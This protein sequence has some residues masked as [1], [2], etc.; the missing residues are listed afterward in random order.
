MNEPT[1]T[2]QNGFRK[3]LLTTVSA[4]ALLASVHGANAADDESSHPPLWIELGGQFEHESG[5]SEQF[6]PAFFNL[7]P[8]ADLAPMFDAQRPSPYSLGEEGKISFQPDGTNWVFAAAI[9]YGRSNNARHSHHQTP[10]HSYGK[11]YLSYTRIIGSHFMPLLERYGDGQT[12]HRESHLVVDFQAGKDVGLGMLGA[13]GSSIINAGVRFAQFTSA[14]DVSLH[15]QPIVNYKFVSQPGKYR[16]DLPS[17]SDFNAVLHAQRSTHAIGPS[18]SWDASMPLVGTGTDATINFDW[19]ANAAF[20]FG[21][22][23]AN[24]QHST[25]GYHVTKPGPLLPKNRSQYT[26]IPPDQN[27]AHAVTI[28]NVGGFAGV[29]MKFSNAKLSLGYRADF[30]FGAIDG[31]IDAAKKENAGFYGPFATISVGL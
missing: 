16:I 10:P 28:P 3:Q 17:N 18:L 7:T 1:N 24:T 26:L 5:G 8:Q 29:S 31:G 4:L 12:T 11:I 27:R 9:R 2:Q 14:S 6:A 23:R 19:G 20:L 15:A 22:Q 21:R 25:M 30:F 13:H